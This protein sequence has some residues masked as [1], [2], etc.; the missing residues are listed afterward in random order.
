MYIFGVILIHSCPAVG[1]HVFVRSLNGTMVCNGVPF[2]PSHLLYRIL[3]SVTNV[4]LCDPRVFIV[5][6]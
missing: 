6:L 1:D 4:R 2:S 5:E 3:V